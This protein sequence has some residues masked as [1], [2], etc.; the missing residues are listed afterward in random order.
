MCSAI[1]AAVGQ[2]AQ[3]ANDLAELSDREGAQR[4]TCGGRSRS[5]QVCAK[6]RVALS[7]GWAIKQSSVV[8]GGMSLAVGAGSGGVSVGP[9]TGNAVGNVVSERSR[10]LAQAW[11]ER[12]PPHS[13]Q[14]GAATTGRA[15]RRLATGIA[16]LVLAPRAVALVPV[17]EA[18]GMV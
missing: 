16:A 11:Q 15:Q 17:F 8:S 9:G 6:C 2:H 1:A 7:P 18:I 10:R 5:A 12:F 4:G 14:R 13:G 3:L